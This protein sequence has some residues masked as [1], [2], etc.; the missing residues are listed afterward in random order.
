VQQISIHAV[1]DR[2]RE[3][4]MSLSPTKPQIAS[5]LII[6]DYGKKCLVMLTVSLMQKAKTR[7][8]CFSIMMGK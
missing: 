4:R 8:F 3:N 1:H 6:N 7:P 2:A 5:M